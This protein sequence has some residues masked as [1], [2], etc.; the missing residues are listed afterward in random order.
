MYPYRPIDSR[1]SL[2]L[3]SGRATLGSH[4]PPQFGNLL[5]LEK[6]PKRRYHDVSWY[7]L[8]SGVIKMLPTLAR[9]CVSL[10]TPA[11]LAELR[12]GWSHSDS[13]VSVQIVKAAEREKE[14]WRDR[15]SDRS[16]ELILKSDPQ[17]PDRAHGSEQ[18]AC[19]HRAECAQQRSSL[20]A[21]RS[22]PGRITAPRDLRRFST[23]PTCLPGGVQTGLSNRFLNHSI[24]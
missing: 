8:L 18:T 11:S 13:S 23:R 3:A 24:Y 17:I 16:E 6:S 15:R 10:A 5:W 20:E 4:P 7:H 12:T 9:T 22:S 1:K 19:F 14:P 2:L 21:C